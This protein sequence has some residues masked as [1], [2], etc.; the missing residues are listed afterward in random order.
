MFSSSVLLLTAAEEEGGDLWWKHARKQG[1]GDGEEEEDDG[2]NE[3]KGKEALLRNM[4]AREQE[5]RLSKVWQDKFEKAE[6]RADYDWLEE[7][8]ELQKTVV[9]E[10]VRL[11]GDEMEMEMEEGGRA[12]MKTMRMEAALH[13][14]RMFALDHPELAL[15]VS[16]KL[17]R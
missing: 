10:Y 5:L 14:L 3:K 17:V 8:I 9:R 1:S 16:S 13:D 7:A 4:L 11:D 2:G 12:M 6:K 15:Q